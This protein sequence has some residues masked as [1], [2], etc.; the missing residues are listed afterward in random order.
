MSVSV[1]QPSLALSHVAQRCCGG[2]LRHT[3]RHC[4]PTCASA[5]SLLV[6]ISG[7][8]SHQTGR[9]RRC[10]LWFTTCYVSGTLGVEENKISNSA[11]VQ[12][13]SHMEAQYRQDVDG[14]RSLGLWPHNARSVARFELSHPCQAVT[15][16]IIEDCTRRATARQPT[17]QSRSQRYK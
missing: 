13:S 6:N 15:R 16:A 3:D 9:V 4:H 14:S 11:R 12:S 8:R 2:R 1:A 5:C 17:A 7:R 10:A